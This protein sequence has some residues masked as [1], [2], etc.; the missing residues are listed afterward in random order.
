MYVLQLVFA[1]QH[2]DC[3]HAPE[4]VGVGGNQIKDHLGRIMPDSSRTVL[5]VDD[6]SPDGTA[7]LVEGVAE[8]VGDVSVMRR[9]AKSGLGPLLELAISGAGDMISGGGEARGHATRALDLLAQG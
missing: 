2:S 1:S 3:V 5:V 6:A 8:Q 9:P 7:D 4:G